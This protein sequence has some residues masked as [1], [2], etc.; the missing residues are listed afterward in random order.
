MILLIFYIIGMPFAYASFNSFIY[1]VVRLSTVNVPRYSTLLTTLESNDFLTTNLKKL[2]LVVVVLCSFAS[3]LISYLAL[4]Q[5]KQRGEKLK[6]FRF[7]PY[8]I[9]KENLK[10]L[11]QY[12]VLKNSD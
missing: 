10:I 12:E 8:Y 1:S 7:N 3:I 5:L 6:L 11:K 4:R 2:S 9:S